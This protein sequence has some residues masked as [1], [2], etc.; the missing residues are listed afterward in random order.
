MKNQILIHLTLHHQRLVFKT[1]KKIIIGHYS[2]YNF[3]TVQTWVNFSVAFNGYV[4]IQLAK[5][6]LQLQ[7]QFYVSQSEFKATMSQTINVK[8]IT[9]FQFRL[10]EKWFMLFCSDLAVLVYFRRYW[11]IFK[12]PIESRQGSLLLLII[13]NTAW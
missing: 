10:L 3:C 12:D 1:A 8:C 11:L 9:Q 4:D 2:E 5:K 7:C 13:I 6:L